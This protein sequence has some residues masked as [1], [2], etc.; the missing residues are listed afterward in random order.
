MVQWLRLIAFDVGDL[1]SIPGQGTGSQMLQLKEPV[2]QKAR[3][4]K[5]KITFPGG[6]DGKE[7]ACHARDLGSIPGS[8]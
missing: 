2:C 7:S 8:G 6:S 1:G 4:D 3:P 5:L